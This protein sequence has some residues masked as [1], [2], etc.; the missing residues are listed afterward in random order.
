MKKYIIAIICIVFIFAGVTLALVLPEEEKDDFNLTLQAEDVELYVGNSQK[1][2][3][4]CSINGI[5]VVKHITNSKIATIQDEYITAKKV[6]ETELTLEAKYKGERVTATIVVTVLEEPEETPP[7]QTPDGDTSEEEELTQAPE[8]PAEQ[9]PVVENPVILFEEENLSNCT[10]QNNIITIQK[11]V[12]GKFSVSL[13]N[14]VACVITVTSE[15]EFVEV[16]KITSMSGNFYKIK[17]TA[18]GQYEI[19]MSVNGAEVVK[20][21]VVVI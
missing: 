6:G 20:F 15:S 14:N 7:S 18:V 17:G 2:E 3:Y 16:T 19:F 13:Q 5:P 4:S 9:E 21:S 10:V 1:L 11:D 12:V 8:E